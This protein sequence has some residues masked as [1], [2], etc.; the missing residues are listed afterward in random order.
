VLADSEGGDGITTFELLALSAEKLIKNPLILAL[1]VSISLN[2][3]R[4]EIPELVLNTLSLVRRSALP[5]ALFMLGASL[6]GFRISGELSQAS[7]IILLKQVAQPL[8]VYVLVFQIFDLPELWGA[9]AVI[10]SALPTGVNAA[11]FANKY[12]AAVAPV[13]TA[14]L[15]STLIS[16]GTISVLLNLFI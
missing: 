11:V 13:G 12:N 16:I 4:V 8:L 7:I 14:V 15:L 2:W 6:V 3:L 1:I 10:A 5:P 9:V